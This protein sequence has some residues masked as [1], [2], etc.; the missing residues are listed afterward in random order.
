MARTLGRES[1]R[2]VVSG[3]VLTMVGAGLTLV[4]LHRISDLESRRGHLAEA[5]APALETLADLRGQHLA[6]LRA[7]DAALHSQD[8]VSQ[9]LLF[10]ESRRALTDTDAAWREYQ[11]A[12]LELAEED[13]RQARYE[14]LQNDIETLGGLVGL[15]LLDGQSLDAVLTAPTFEQL[16]AARLERDGLVTAMRR[17]HERAQ[18]RALGDLD[19]SIGAARQ[20]VV[21]L[22]LV[23]LLC[24]TVVF[25][26]ILRTTLRHE[27]TAAAADIER[28]ARARRDQLEARL[29]RALDMARSEAAAFSVVQ[30]SLAQ[31]AP[32]HPSELLVA[33]SDDANFQRVLE[34]GPEGRGP[35]CPVVSAAT[36][37]AAVSAEVRRFPDSDALDACPHLQERA[38]GSCGA[39]CVPVRLASTGV[40]VLHLTAPVGELPDPETSGA[41]ELLA[42]Q[43][44]ERLGLL[45]LLAETTQQARH[46]PLTGL[47]NRRSLVG[48]VERLVADESPYVVAYGDLDRFKRLN[49]EHGHDTGDRALRLFSRVLR[50]HVRPLDLVAR[51]GGEEFLVVL[52]RCSS[53]EAAEVV[54]RVRR[55]L[56]HELAGSSIPPFTVSFG[57]ASASAGQPF[58]EAVGRADRALMAAKAAGRDRVLLDASEAPSHTGASAE[59]D[60]S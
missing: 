57:V 37:P 18:T 20:E 49:D 27:R 58:E 38:D 33:D 30:R 23:M 54:E 47:L 39:I 40:A 36:C 45:R 11:R 51:Y 52:P 56:A 43:A 44:G 21:V 34:T 2:V 12:S 8:Q 15:A 42:A 25:T 16:T 13:T 28:A 60:R 55:G 48:A 53:T 5:T 1:T 46:D 10:E 50:D 35:G 9:A 3:V 59:P 32:Q 19:R 29:H 22:L 31:I 24:G 6:E 17:E 4:S 14:A 26:T 7:F 41:V